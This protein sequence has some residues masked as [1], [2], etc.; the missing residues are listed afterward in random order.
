M[1]TKTITHT[2]DRSHSCAACAR[3]CTLA[4]GWACADSDGAAFP[5]YGPYNHSHVPFKAAIT[6]CDQFEAKVAED[7]Q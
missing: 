6:T 2:L 4:M 7:D 1:P 5:K 3:L